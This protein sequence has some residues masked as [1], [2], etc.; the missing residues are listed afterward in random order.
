[1]LAVWAIKIKM[2][3]ITSK[4]GPWYSQTSDSKKESTDCL[5]QIY[6]KF[7]EVYISAAQ[8]GTI[9]KGRI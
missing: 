7:C 8:K 4:R 2:F 5:S 6:L 1:M 9:L 3:R